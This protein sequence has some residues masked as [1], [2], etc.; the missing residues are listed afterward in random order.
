MV[1]HVQMNQ[2][3]KI[4][5]QKTEPD[6]YFKLIFGK[7]KQPPDRERCICGQ[8]IQEQ[9]QKCPKENISTETIIIVGSEC[10]DKFTKIKLKGRRCECCGALHKNRDF[11][12]CNEHVDITQ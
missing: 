3:K 7:L 12:L 5:H 6:N 1:E 2:E 11:K 10:I 8:H 9:C 4:K